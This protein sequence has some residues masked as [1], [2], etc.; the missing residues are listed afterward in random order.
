MLG[1]GRFSGEPL[2]LGIP[3][4]QLPSEFKERQADLRCPVLWLPGWEG[5]PKEEQVPFLPQKPSQPGG[6][7]RFLDWKQDEV[8][9]ESGVRC[10][11]WPCVCMGGGGARKEPLC[12][13][14]GKGEGMHMLVGTHVHLWVPTCMCVC[15]LCVCLCPHRPGVPIFHAI[16]PDNLKII[17]I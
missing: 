12:Q 13:G 15:V 1:S 14:G 2:P 4:P 3:V 9:H 8:G 16:F 6:Q 10:L 5:M 11:L 7:V 17:S